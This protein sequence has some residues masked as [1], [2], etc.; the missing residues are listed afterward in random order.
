MATKFTPALD[1]HGL[2]KRSFLVHLIEWPSYWWL[3]SSEG[4]TTHNTEARN[5]PADSPM[6]TTGMAPRN[7][8]DSLPC[9]GGGR[10]LNLD[11]I[12]PVY[13]D[14]TPPPD[15][16]AFASAPWITH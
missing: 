15:P 16:R 3:L 14:C 5:A 9:R 6:N 4:T 10:P 2:P 7:P 12:H 1:E 11:R 8:A 13:K